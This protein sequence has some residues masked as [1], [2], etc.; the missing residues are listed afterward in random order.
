M[1]TGLPA[2]AR[3]AKIQNAWP[4]LLRP[5]SQEQVSLQS[6]WAASLCRGPVQIPPPEM[7][8]G[9]EAIWPS[10]IC[11]VPAACFDQGCRGG[12]KRAGTST[13]KRWSGEPVKQVLG[14][15]GKALVRQGSGSS[16]KHRRWLFPAGVPRVLYGLGSNAFLPWPWRMAPNYHGETLALGCS[17]GTGQ[18]KPVSEHCSPGL[19]AWNPPL[20]TSAAP[21]PSY[22]PL[23][24]C[25]R[26]T[27]DSVDGLCCAGEP[28]Q[29]RGLAGWDGGPR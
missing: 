17:Q 7:G 14:H 9:L 18:Q 12:H 16:D 28:L 6:G 29:L 19:W 26:P 3:Q 10:R 5:A 22:G 2:F 24:T 13:D 4:E 21:G 25:N 23:L 1:F 8:Q 15:I 11:Q 27:A 20:T